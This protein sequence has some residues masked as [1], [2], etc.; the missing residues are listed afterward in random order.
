M[1]KIRLLLA[2]S[3]VGITAVHY[4]KMYNMKTKVLVPLRIL[5]QA[6]SNM[7]SRIPSRAPSR[8]GNDYQYRPGYAGDN[9]NKKSPYPCIFHVNTY[10]L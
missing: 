9:E 3:A 10:T 1:D 2:V 8:A 7:G 6:Y 5:E 4:G